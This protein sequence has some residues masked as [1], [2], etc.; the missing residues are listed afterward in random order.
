M[1]PTR[2]LHLVGSPTDDFNLRLSRLYAAGCIDAT[3]DPARYQFEIAYVTPDRK[4]RFPGSLA[5]PDV[6]AAPTME[7]GD[8]IAHV[9][10]LDIDVALPQMFCHEGMTT[11]RGIFEALGIPYLGN[12]PLQMAIAADKAKTRA[13]VAAAG[14]QTPRGELLGRGERPSLAAPAVVKPNT[15]DNSAGVSLVSHA[16]EFSAAIDEAFRHADQILVEQF[17]PPGREVRCGV[18][19]REGELVCLPLEEYFLDPA[20][21]PIRR[22]EHKLSGNEKLSL[23]SKDA[24]QSWIVDADDPIVAGV[25]RAA[26]LA[27]RTLGC[28][29]YS[30]FDFRIDA[31]GSAYFIEAGLYCSFSPQSVI[32]TMMTAHGTPLS[33]FF[34]EAIDRVRAEKNAV[35]RDEMA[36]FEK[37]PRPPRS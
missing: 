21:R 22:Y 33:K 28:R 1:R 14:I 6:A 32:A 2:I 23:T 31:T 8:A 27:H 18:V 24:S 37:P 30:L 13:I 3:G 17:I 36:T 34:A 4:W 16:D 10:D 35:N 5:D 26:R 29:H 25:H 19:E 15:S 7:M 11:Y 12:R 20:D 9:T